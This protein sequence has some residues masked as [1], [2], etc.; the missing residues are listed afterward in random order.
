MIGDHICPV[1]SIPPTSAVILSLPM[2]SPRAAENYVS[3][4]QQQACQ[5]ELYFQLHPTLSLISKELLTH[6]SPSMI[7]NVYH[8]YSFGI[9]IFYK[10]LY[11]TNFGDKG[12]FSFLNYP[13]DVLRLPHTATYQPTLARWHPKYSESLFAIRMNHKR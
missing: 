9:Y 2:L 13:A 6:C 1:F 11:G 4:N 10:D 8:S 5:Q 12:F 3:W 7:S